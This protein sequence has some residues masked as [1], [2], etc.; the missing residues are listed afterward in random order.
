MDVVSDQDYLTDFKRGHTGFEET[1]RYYTKA[2]GRDLDEYN[3]TVRLNRFNVNR[4][5]SRYNLNA[6]IR[7]YDDVV[8]RTQ[9]L[10]DTT[11]QRLPFIGFTGS[12]QAAGNT[13]FLFDLDTSYTHFY[14]E[15]TTTSNSV[16]QDHRFDR[17]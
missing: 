1:R 3:D 10:D 8:A 9:D 16:T 5:W 2:F 13:P 14:R 11:V 12:K 17:C 6:E 15:A 7:W 4:S